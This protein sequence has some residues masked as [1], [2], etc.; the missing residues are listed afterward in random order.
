MNQTL[1]PFPARETFFS[2]RAMIQIKIPLPVKARGLIGITKQLLFCEGD[3]MRECEYCRSPVADN[4]YMC[5][6]CCLEKKG[7][8]CKECGKR[9]MPRWDKQYHRLCESC[10]RKSK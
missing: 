10:Y 5:Y 4:Y 3:N 9:F 8:K 2:G 1:L 7:K 6:S